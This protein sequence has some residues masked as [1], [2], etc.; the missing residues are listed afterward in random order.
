MTIPFEKLK[1]RL[2]ANPKVKAEYDALAPE[3]EIAAELL[4]A[5]LRAGLSQAE[6]AARIRTSQSTIARLESGQTLPSTKTLPTIN[7]SVYQGRPT[8]DKILLDWS[9]EDRELAAAFTHTDPWRIMRMQGEFVEGFDALAEIGPAISIFQIGPRRRESRYF[10]AARETARKLSEVG[11]T[12]ITGGGP[13][14]MEAANQGAYEAGGC[15]VGLNIQLP[16]EQGLNSFVNLPLNFRYFFVR[17]VMFV[18][19]AEGFIIFP[20]GFGT[21]D[22]LFEALTLCRTGKL[23]DFPIILCR[24]LTFGTRSFD[25]LSRICLATGW[26]AGEVLERL[27]VTDDIDRIVEV[28]LKAHKS[29]SSYVRAYSASRI[30]ARR[31]PRPYVHR[32]VQ[33]GM[34]AR[35]RIQ[36]GSL[37]VPHCAGDPILS[38]LVRS[39]RTPKYS[40]A[41]GWGSLTQ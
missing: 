8:D 20:G 28:M 18:K 13:G 12:V 29:R 7:R 25:G 39:R 2:L 26:C 6:L 3:F 15:S 37:G 21:L 36:P 24:Q 38:R 9:P 31:P 19:Y 30:Q 11:F 32:P 40:I 33:S 5:R 1:A 41:A 17:K 23:S 35:R 4:R 16:H 22:E 34:L 10:Q 14:I 27:I